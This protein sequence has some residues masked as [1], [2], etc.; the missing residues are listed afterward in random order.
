[1]TAGPL[2]DAL[3][4]VLDGWS[5]KDKRAFV[6][7]AT[8]SSR[9]PAPK[10]ELLQVQMPF[11]ALSAAEEAAMLGMLPQAHT[12]D[13]V[14]E[15]PDYWGALC[16]KKGVNA[17]DDAAR[18]RELLEELRDV[19]DA[20]LRTAVLECA[21]YGLDEPGGGDPFRYVVSSPA[22]CTT[23]GGARRARRTRRA[24]RA[25]RRHTGVAA[26]CRG[27]L[28]RG[29]RGEWHCDDRRRRRRCG[30]DHR[31]RRCRRVRRCVA[32]EDGERAAQSRRRRSARHFSR[33]LSCRRRP[34][35]L[36]D[37]MAEQPPADAPPLWRPPTGERANSPPI[38]ALQDVQLTSSLCGIYVSTSAAGGCPGPRSR[39]PAAA[40]RR[41]RLAIEQ[42]GAR[43]RP[44]GASRRDATRSGGARVRR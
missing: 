43:I 11:S 21:E 24:R 23:G 16:A 41:A 3:W 12:C 35:L 39:Q 29:G 15:L 34:G 8:G 25:R 2:G 7:F 4:S 13:N 6:L 19:I 28:R 1:M 9:L 26:R 37:R 31:D 38:P 17:D 44:D 42:G 5:A 20:R 10:S 18:R 33:R 36:W 40:P 27:C 32:A 22:A 30:R 14:L